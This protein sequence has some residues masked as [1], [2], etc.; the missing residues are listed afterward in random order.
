MG[1]SG[2][3]VVPSVDEAVAASK[4]CA[5]IAGLDV[6]SAEVIAVGYSVR[7][8]L[9]PAQ[10]VSRVIIEGQVLRGDPIPWLRREVE[11]ASFLATSGAALVP[12]AKAPG[13]FHAGG[14]DVTFWQ[15]LEPQSDRVTQRQFAALLFNLHEHLNSYDGELPVLVGPLTD[16]EAALGLSDDEMLH[17][18]AARLLPE[19][20]EWPRRPLHGDAHTGNLLSTAQG[21]LWLDFE[22][23]CL[24][25][26]EW[27]F[28]SRTITDEAI[29]AYPGQ[30]D[31]HLLQR[32]RQLRRLQ[33]LAAVLTSDIDP[34]AE[35]LLHDLRNALSAELS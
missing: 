6:R 27:D 10:V 22:D 31:P 35:S 1:L 5:T 18:V 12:P 26:L 7:V 16:V 9:Q 11:V 30:L 13:P 15:W 25:P 29:A 19:A 8:L 28:A 33:I 17:H 34:E 3:S 2:G 23:A 20:R 14:L 21:H 24:G 32:C 4:A